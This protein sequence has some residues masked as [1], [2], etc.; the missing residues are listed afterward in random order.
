MVSA[1]GTGFGDDDDLGAVGK[2]M[3]KVQFL[4][5]IHMI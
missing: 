3:V 5:A 4:A 2:G 1:R